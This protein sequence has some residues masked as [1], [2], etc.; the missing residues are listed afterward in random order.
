MFRCSLLSL[1]FITI[2]SVW[3]YYDYQPLTSSTRPYQVINA[4][5]GNGPQVENRALFGWSVANI[6]D[7]NGDGFQDLAVGAIG[8]SCINGNGTVAIRCGAVYILFMDYDNTV[9]THTRITNFVNGGP[10]FLQSNDNFG[11]AVAPAGDI[12]GDGVLDVLVGCPETTQGGSV[13]TLLMNQDGTVREFTQIRGSIG[14]GPP[15]DFY[16]RFGSAIANIGVL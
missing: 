9:K 12:D 3:T 4:T 6:G 13:Y 15:V 7:L 11:Y 8:D 1:S 2:H 10:L 16:S 14:N 5:S